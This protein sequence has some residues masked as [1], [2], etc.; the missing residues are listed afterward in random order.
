[1][2][3]GGKSNSP[4]KTEE[5]I[6]WAGTLPMLGILGHIQRQKTSYLRELT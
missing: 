5:S 6:L 3:E 2:E 4:N 1:L